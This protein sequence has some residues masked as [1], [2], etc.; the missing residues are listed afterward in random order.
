MGG[1]GGGGAC[2]STSTA[3]SVNAHKR[4]VTSSSAADVKQ[5][6]QNNGIA[7][8]N[9]VLVFSTDLLTGT[10]A[11]SFGIIVMGSGNIDHEDFERTLSHE[12]GHAVHARQIGL[13]DYFFTTAIPSLIGAALYPDNTWIQDHYYSLPWERVAEYYG[14]VDRRYSPWA[15]SAGSIFWISTLIAASITPW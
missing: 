4:I 13:V 6:L 15:D 14:N 9:G 7:F 12:Y 1:S 8:H 11:F 5:D 3:R 2:S 10:S